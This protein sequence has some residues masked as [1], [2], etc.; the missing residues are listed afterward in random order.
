MCRLRHFLQDIFNN[1]Q[2]MVLIENKAEEF[3]L[4]IFTVNEHARE[5]YIFPHQLHNHQ[6]NA[7]IA[8]LSKYSY[9]DHL[10]YGIRGKYEKLLVYV[11]NK[12]S[13]NYQKFLGKSRVPFN[14]TYFIEYKIHLNKRNVFLK[15]KFGS[16]D[17]SPDIAEIKQKMKKFSTKYEL[18]PVLVVLGR[19]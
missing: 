7:L 11:F 6:A 12:N 13:T 18:K 16:K 19:E 4:N 10:K 3:A 2:L 5:V 8:F 9:L 15:D 17:I 1:K 14:E